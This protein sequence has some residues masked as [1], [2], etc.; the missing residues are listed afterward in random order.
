[1]TRSRVEEGAPI[2]NHHPQ[3]TSPFAAILN[4]LFFNRDHARNENNFRNVDVFTDVTCLD[5]DDSSLH[6]ILIPC[7]KV[8]HISCWPPKGNLQKPSFNEHCS[9]SVQPLIRAYLYCYNIR[10]EKS[11]RQNG[12]VNFIFDGFQTPL[13]YDSCSS[14]DGFVIYLSIVSAQQTNVPFSRT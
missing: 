9:S 5:I 4:V 8:Q 3:G 2:I 1:M 7:L 14:F 10:K 12:Q 13:V 6:R 11:Y